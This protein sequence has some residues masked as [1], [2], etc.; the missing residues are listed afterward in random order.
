ML[1]LT[2]THVIHERGPQT[3]GATALSKVF[4]DPA[5]ANAFRHL[6]SPTLSDVRSPLTDIQL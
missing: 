2:A 6:Y 1:V 5:W 3:Y 4:L